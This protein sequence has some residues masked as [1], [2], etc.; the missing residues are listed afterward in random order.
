MYS[1]VVVVVVV[2]DVG[3]FCRPTRHA[4]Y[5]KRTMRILYKH[6]TYT[7]YSGNQTDRL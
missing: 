6:I 1:L 7:S 5:P 3:E 2:V 4:R